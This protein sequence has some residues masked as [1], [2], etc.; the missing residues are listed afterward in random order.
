MKT[1]LILILFLY[2]CGFCFGATGAKYLIITPDNFIS[3]V[4]PL[5][6][7]KTKKGVKAMVA[8][9]SVTG[10]STSQIKSYITNAYNTWDIRPQYIL[11]A[12]FGTVLPASGSSDDY[13]ADMSGN[14]RI[15]LSVG[16]L[17]CTSVDQCNMMVAK[18]LGYERNPYLGD[19]LW[20]R[21]GT[22]I[23]RED[24]PPDQYYQSDCRYIRNLMLS[25]SFVLT[26]SLSST[27]GH[28][29]TN[30]MNAI[31]NGRSYVVYRGQ[32]VT[33][34]WSPFDQV[35]PSSMTNGFMLPVVVS[36]TCAT[37]SLT[38]TNYYGDRFLTA[39]TAQN[40]KG[41]VAYFGTTGIG[42]S[43]Y[44]GTV[45]RGF[46]KALFEERTYVLGDATK[47]AKFILDSLYGNQTRYAEWNL[48]GD[49]ELN[50]WTATPRRL[51]VTHDTVI[52][53]L[54]QVFTVTVNSGSVACPGA[55]VCLMM[56]T[57]IYQ[58]AYTNG[59][60]I[61]TLN[62]SPRTIGTMSVTVT[63]KNLKPYEGSVTIRPDTL[64]HDVGIMSIIEPQ[65]LVS[66][67]T[68]IVPKVKVK[69][70]GLNTDTFSVSFTIGS[71]YNQTLS[72]VILDAGDTTTLSFPN[73]TAVGGT[74]SI[75]TYTSLNSDQYH[76][77]D[78]AYSSVSVVV[79][80]DVG[81]DAILSPDSS[82]MLNQVIIPKARVKNY[83]SAAQSNFTATCSIVS[84]NGTI[85]YTNTQTISSLAPNDTT[86]INF[87]NW[88]PTIA[89]RCTVK[90]RT[91]LVG[92]QNPSNDAKTKV[93]TIVMLFINEGFNSSSFP[94]TGWQTVAS[95]S[96]N[97]E[98]SSQ[99][100]YPTCSPYEGAGMVTYQS[101]YASSGNAARLITP[102]IPASGV[103]RCSLK[104]AM[105]HDPGYS[106]SADQVQVQTS[107][108]GTTF[109]TVATFNRY[110][111]TEAWAEHSVYLGSFSSNFYVAFY[112]VSAYGNN[113]FI[114][115]VRL[116]S[117]A[118][119]NEGEIS[120]SDLLTQTSLNAPKPNPVIN[121]IANISFTIASPSNAALKIYDAS[122]RLIKTLVDRNF[123]KG[124]YNYNWN[125]NDENNRQ[126]AEGIYFCA[127]E[128][129]KQKFTKK[130]ILTR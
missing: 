22:T 57:L 84:S 42:T 75:V 109:T 93:I 126:I 110:S 11:L 94:P 66:L 107:T 3:A 90:M 100:T 27:Q 32:A 51:I 65:G 83:G 8:P 9:L 120:S 18:I 82:Q 21:K 29:S 35:N 129:P 70:Y 64:A 49:P 85:R 103:T 96:Y 123:E 48:F 61:A 111:A 91:N 23:I 16:R 12:G 116:F 44:R 47:R 80:N 97:W 108:N 25:N 95:G 5:A 19:S 46:F 52:G 81:I 114:D 74:H 101:F 7:W 89:E 77:N 127:L 122:G 33:N 37:M 41:S 125:S 43:V 58:T 2:L 45:A 78:T 55:L 14:Y 106:S 67:G 15:E 68:N 13:Y 104:F 117:P 86:I 10:N 118:G 99:G 60:G 115:Y 30:V 56:D 119:I 112:A 28:N 76:A 128:T 62:I 59:S 31:N 6:D 36:G 38:S 92:D 1:K 39:G 87:S 79:P 24:A 53:T 130:L 34:W 40:P 26:E 69:N 63:G 4:Q 124:V 50:L 88:T 102:V 73:W 121:G 113:M 105:M 54:P 17:P 71:V 20:F 98:W 72:T